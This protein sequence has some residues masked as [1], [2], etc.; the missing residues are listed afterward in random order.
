MFKEEFE[1]AAS[2][3]AKKC[4]YLSKNPIGYFLL[5]ILA[6]MY[7]G[8]GILL[9]FSVGGM[10]QGLPA[11]K[12]AM[13]AAFG[14]ALSLVVMAGAELFTGN[15]M[16]MMAGILRQKVNLAQAV[17]LWVICWIGNA[18][19]GILLAILYHL[20]G[21][22]NGAVGEFMA[23]GALGK[24]TAAP[25]AL[26]A[27]G[28]LCN[29]LVCAAV[30]CGFRCKSESGKLIMIFWCLL[31]FFTCGFEHSVA[32]MTLLSYALINP[33]GQAVT[34]GGWLYNLALVTVGNMIGGI[35]F[36]AFPYALA[37]KD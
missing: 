2:A 11:A 15:N 23:A 26:L 22:G 18:V 35:C 27:R 36:M 37:Q 31:V 1:A 4:S 16:V 25:V 10:L 30:W 33:A 21:L 34:V 6:G 17:K 32:N 8:F 9:A 24:M 7:I 29:M 14:A 3:A 12:L 20:T 5:S 28:I 19:G 13:G